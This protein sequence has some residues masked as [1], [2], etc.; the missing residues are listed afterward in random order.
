MKKTPG[1]GTDKMQRYRS[2]RELKAVEI[3]GSDYRIRTREGATGIAVTAIHGGGI[4][5]GTTEIAEAVAGTKHAFYTFSGLKP[6]GNSRLHVTSRHFTEP[7]ALD[8]VRR[9][10]TV[11]SIHGCGDS[12]PVVLLGGRHIRLGRQIQKSLA[13]AGFAV[14]RSLRFPGLSPLNICNRCRLKMGVQL[15]ISAGLRS[16]LFGGLTR[17]QRKKPS[18]AAAC[19]TA[20]VQ[21]ALDHLL[22]ERGGA[23]E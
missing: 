18:A 6:D 5:P 8:L 23:L 15:E 20:A 10:R 14:R 4:E 12:E 21:A 16:R 19:F 3:A 2:F 17:V 13:E 11:V 9:A 22:I 1:A 7:R